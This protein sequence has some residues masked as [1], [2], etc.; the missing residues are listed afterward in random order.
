MFNGEI[1]YNATAKRKEEERKNIS[2]VGTWKCEKKVNEIAQ[3]G[4]EIRLL[5]FHCSIRRGGVVYMCVTKSEKKN[6]MVKFT[7]INFDAIPL[8][9]NDK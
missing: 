8:P 6:H 1:E 4:L 3:R 2:G 7:C 9:K 5:Y